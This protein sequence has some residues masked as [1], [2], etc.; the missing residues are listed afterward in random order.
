MTNPGRASKNLKDLGI[1]PYEK[2]EQTFTLKNHVD[3]NLS[4]EEQMDRI[5]NY[6]VNISRKFPPLNVVD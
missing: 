6:F 1:N 5:L 4:S 3:E 2:E